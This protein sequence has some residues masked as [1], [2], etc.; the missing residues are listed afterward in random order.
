MGTEYRDDAA[1]WRARAEEARRLASQM[2][3]TKAGE[4]MLDIA[5][6]YDKIAK[7]TEERA[8]ATAKAPS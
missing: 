8:A 1:H 3:D 4:A 5:D 6:R 7:H 2:A